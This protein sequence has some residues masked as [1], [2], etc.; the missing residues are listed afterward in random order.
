MSL[1]G[2]HWW[3]VFDCQQPATLIR[4]FVEVQHSSSQ[5]YA[6]NRFKTVTACKLRR[7]C[8]YDHRWAMLLAFLSRR[9]RRSFN[10]NFIPLIGGGAEPLAPRA[11]GILSTC[12]YRPLGHLFSGWRVCGHVIR[13]MIIFS[14]LQIV[15]RNEQS[16]FDCNIWACCGVFIWRLLIISR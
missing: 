7:K 13:L 1:A 15:G 16:D 4:S 14:D 9:R 5:Q 11:D 12:H 2:L 3:D 8:Y 6:I 10:C